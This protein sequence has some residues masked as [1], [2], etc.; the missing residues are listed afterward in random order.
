MDKNAWKNLQNILNT[1]KRLIILG[2]VH[3]AGINTSVINDFVEHMKI[4]V[5]MIELEVKW[6]KIFR[7]LKHKPSQFI[8]AIN[9]ENW[10]RESGLI[11]KEHILLY[12][13]YMD[14]RKTI[15]PIKIEDKV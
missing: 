2:E 3:G 7:L 13:K 15:L 6:Q 1:K 12:K 11:G 4:K 10:I 14:Q 5:I 8:N 9:K